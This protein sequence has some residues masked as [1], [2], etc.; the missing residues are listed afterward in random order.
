MG[1]SVRPWFQAVA[2]TLHSDKAGAATEDS[3]GVDVISKAGRCRFTLG[4]A[5]F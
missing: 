4:I 1:T 3:D 5:M 2:R